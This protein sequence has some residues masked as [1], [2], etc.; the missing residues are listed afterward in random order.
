MTALNAL[1]PAPTAEAVRVSPRL[2]TSAVLLTAS[3]AAA[4]AVTGLAEAAETQAGPS[5]LDPVVAADVVGIRTPLLTA[6]AHG[7]TFAGS[8][9]VVGGLALVLLVGLVVRGHRTRA[10]TFAFGMAGSVALTVIVKLLVARARPP[11]L[12]R[13]GAV[14]ATY[15]FP[16][17][18]TLN[19]AVLLVLATSL[20][21]A[22]AK[23][24]T[25]V[26][27]VTFDA[28]MVAGVALSR[29]YLGYH[30]ATDVLASGLVA[31]AWLSLVWLLN[32]LLSRAVV[33]ALPGSR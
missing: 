12:D 15:A 10:A 23:T 6:L 8:E 2:R 13:L 4:A 29:V 33:R 30:W 24:R 16:S 3:A 19:S 31:L 9:V 7:F 18:H 21:W 17:G 26:A 20:L 27:L 11:A 32:P 1:R 22:G 25:R 14:D 5:R 28:V